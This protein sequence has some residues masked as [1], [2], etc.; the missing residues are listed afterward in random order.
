M[1][2]AGPQS[3]Q[4][5]FWRR[6]ARRINTLRRNDAAVFLRANRWR[7]CRASSR[8]YHPKMIEGQRTTADLR[9]TPNRCKA[10]PVVSQMEVSVR[11]VL[12]FVGI[13][14]VVAWS[15]SQA[16]NVPAFRYAL[17]RWPA[18]PYQ[19][20]VYYESGL[21]GNAL[22]LLQRSAANVSVRPVDVTTPEGKALAARRDIIVYPWVEVFYPVHFQPDRPLW[23]GP[24]TPDAVRRIIDSPTRS[25]L[26]KMLLGGEVAAWILVKS[27]HETQDGRALQLL[28]TNLERASSTLRMPELG[29]DL[30]GNPVEVRD[31][32]THPVHFGLLEVTRDDPRETLLVNALLQ[33]EPDLAEQNEPI[34]F[35]V[36]GRGRALYALVG[37]GI[38]ADNIM[39][40]C[41]SLLNWCSCEIKA[42]NP[43]TDLLIDAD[44]SRPYGGRMVVHPE[45]PQLAGLDGFR[46]D[47]KEADAMPE[48]ADVSIPPPVRVACS[49][50]SAQVEPPAQHKDPIVRNTLY[51]AGAGCLVLVGISVF[52]AARTRR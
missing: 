34:A 11:R 35:P 29:T 32:K 31:F 12:V 50:S 23:S 45:L 6:T 47:R 9:Y 52:V 22:D 48:V 39:E 10:V 41:Q 43:G 14:T 37:A 42:E 38:Q 30:N 19:V 16:C 2:Q 7:T 17:E 28:R 46:M 15:D 24:L 27:G 8:A 3:A 4:I 21:R 36:F 25:D 26:A 51:L 1:P 40:A 33:S 5:Q 20:L 49:A 44:W 18:D 13:L